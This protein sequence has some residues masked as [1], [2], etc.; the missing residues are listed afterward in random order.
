MEVLYNV[1]NLQTPPPMVVVILNQYRTGL[2][3][4]FSSY[5]DREFCLRKYLSGNTTVPAKE[6]AAN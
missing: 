4:S 6:S 3:I 1:N 2:L 5:K